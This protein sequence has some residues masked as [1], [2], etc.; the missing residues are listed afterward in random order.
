[1]TH[2][3][4]Y[5]LMVGPDSNTEHK[6]AVL[7]KASSLCATWQRAR[8]AGSWATPDLR[9][10]KLWGRDRNCAQTSCHIN[11]PKV[12]SVQRP[13]GAG[14]FIVGSDLLAQKPASTRLKSSHA[15]F[16]KHNPKKQILG[17]FRACLLCIPRET[18]PDSCQ[19]SDKRN[20]QL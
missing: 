16:F 7:K 9:N 6:A 14:F 8:S 19:P 5:A 18:V 17:P 10:P 13:P 11:E 2:Q 15:H 4:S 1:M 3:Q 20:L 12:A